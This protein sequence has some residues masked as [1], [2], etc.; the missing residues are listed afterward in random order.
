VLSFFACCR[1]INGSFLV[2]LFYSITTIETIFLPLYKPFRKLYIEARLCHAVTKQ[3]FFEFLSGVFPSKFG[4]FPV[5]SLCIWCRSLFSLD[6]G[7]F[8]LITDLFPLCSFFF[9]ARPFSSLY[10]FLS[11]LM[12]FLSLIAPV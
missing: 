7:C 12:V 6:T 3:L 2:V 1:K 4:I 10:L 8:R 9:S 11:V 5:L